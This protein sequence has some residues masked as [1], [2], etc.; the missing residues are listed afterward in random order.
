MQNVTKF[1]KLNIL[2]R[3]SISCCTVSDDKRWLVTADAGNDSTI[4]IWDLNT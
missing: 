2:K 3:N 1:S 4:I